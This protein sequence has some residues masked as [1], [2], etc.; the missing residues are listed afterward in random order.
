MK[1]NGHVLCC[2]PEY[3]GARRAV[4]PEYDHYCSFLRNTIGRDN[5][6][7][8]YATIA[9][10]CTTCALLLACALRVLTSSSAVDGGGGGGWEGLA[11]A[12]AV[13]SVVYLVLCAFLLVFHT[14]LA[15]RNLTTLERSRA[16]AGRALG[17]NR[18][19]GAAGAV[20][21]GAGYGG[22]GEHGGGAFCN[23]FDRGYALNFAARLWPATYGPG[24]I[25]DLAQLAA[26]RSGAAA[27]E[28]K[29]PAAASAVASLLVAKPPGD[30]VAAV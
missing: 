17:H 7:D 2:A 28:G 22:G 23:P 24:D 1:S 10:A 11:W 25:D 20:A 27:G 4:V 29:G 18:A 21:G 19:R 8:F 3:C 15:A 14:V 5:Y 16:K 26:W 6:A 9:A 13:L 30:G 12:L